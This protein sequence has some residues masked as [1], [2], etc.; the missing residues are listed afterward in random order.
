MENL[1]KEID[2]TLDFGYSIILRDYTNRKREIARYSGEE[3]A[4][5]FI[6]LT[7]ILHQLYVTVDILYAKELISE[8]TYRTLLKWLEGEKKWMRDLLVGM[9]KR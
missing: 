1:F 2:K 7:M 8:E 4:E 5:K 3:F 6:E 9:I